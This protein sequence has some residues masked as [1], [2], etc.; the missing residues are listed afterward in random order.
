LR[1]IKRYL[2]MNYLKPGKSNKE[3]R[4]N[5]VDYWAEYVRT[6]PDK[7]WSLQQNI[8]I[9]SQMQSAKN[10]PLTAKD[11]LEIKKMVKDKVPTTS[12]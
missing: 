7:D 3:D 10:Y 5:F 9:N 2:K 8:L 6:H 11:Y 1:G 4:L 12:H